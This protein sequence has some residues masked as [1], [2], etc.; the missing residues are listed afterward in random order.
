MQGL[1]SKYLAHHKDVVGKTAITEINK[2][3]SIQHCRYPA[4]QINMAGGGSTSF[5]LNS[6]ISPAFSH[7][8]K[9]KK[10]AKVHGY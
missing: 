7:S 9:G 2:V 1:F 5:L 8:G 4:L 3:G 6:T 10:A